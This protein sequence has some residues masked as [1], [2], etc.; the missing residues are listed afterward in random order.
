MTAQGF[1]IFVVLP[2]CEFLSKMRSSF[3]FKV[4]GIKP[5]HK[6][7][8]QRLISLVFQE[9]WSQHLLSPYEKLY[10]FHNFMFDYFDWATYHKILLGLKV[11]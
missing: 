3:S 2:G 7:R 6:I 11:T 4:F 1:Q 10:E 8:Q 9:G 5:S